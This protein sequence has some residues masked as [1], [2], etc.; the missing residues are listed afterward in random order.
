MHKV[1]YCS[2]AV[3][4]DDILLTGSDS[5]GIVETEMYLKRYFVTNDM[6]RP[7]YFLGIEVAHQ[8]LS[9]I[10]SQRKYALDLLEETWFLGCKPTNTPMEANVDLWL[11]DSHTWFRKIYEIDWETDLSYSD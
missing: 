11:D 5:I 6:G 7:K 1:W 3:Y 2:S 10:L 8:K 4:V 9:V